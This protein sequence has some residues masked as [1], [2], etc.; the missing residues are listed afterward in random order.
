LYIARNRVGWEKKEGRGFAALIARCKAPLKAGIRCRQ[1]LE[2]VGESRGLQK[3]IVFLGPGVADN[4][5]A[6]ICRKKDCL[7]FRPACPKSVKKV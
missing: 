3:R 5:A 2:W 4:K 7:T 6:C 1:T